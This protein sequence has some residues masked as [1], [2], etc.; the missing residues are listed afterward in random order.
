MNVIAICVPYRPAYV[1]IPEEKR[2][3]SKKL[4]PRAKL[5]VL[6]GYEGEN[7]YKIW[8]PSIEDNKLILSSNV[9]FDEST[10]SV[11]YN[12]SRGDRYDSGNENSKS[13]R[14]FDDRRHNITS[15]HFNQQ[16]DQSELSE[17]STE[18]VSSESDRSEDEIQEIQSGDETIR[19]E[20][21][22][23]Q[24]QQ[25]NNQSNQNSTAD[26]S[27]DI[28]PTQEDIYQDDSQDDEDDVIVMSLRRTGCRPLKMSLRYTNGEPMNLLASTYVLYRTGRAST[29]DEQHDPPN[30]IQDQTPLIPP[31]R[32]NTRGDKSRPSSKQAENEAT[33]GSQRPRTKYG[34]YP[35][36]FAAQYMNGTN[37]SMD[38][39][40]YEEAMN[41]PEANHWRAA[42]H[43]EYSQLHNKRKW[44]LCKRSTVPSE[45][46]PLTGKLIFKAIRDQDGKI[47][48]YKARWVVRGFE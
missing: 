2:V 17:I 8:V 1:L 15:G 23:Y 14:C 22:I 4:D 28:E 20:E 27:V 3:R 47:I 44:T 9:R 29:T 38:P 16:I 33:Y 40:T 18:V 10:H 6:V 7:I 30:D 11:S 36:L 42:I 31:K 13:H 35:F 41:R 25:D 32:C 5:G 21:V 24:T 45:F 46:R 12:Q 37:T 39:L 48:K 19:S 34:A 43:K 26:V